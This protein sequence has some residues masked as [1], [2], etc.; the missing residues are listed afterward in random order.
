[1]TSSAGLPVRLTPHILHKGCFVHYPDSSTRLRHVLASTSYGSV[2]TGTWSRTGLGCFRQHDSVDMMF[3][4]TAQTTSRSPGHASSLHPTPRRH[5]ASTRAII[6]K[7]RCPC[8]LRVLARQ[9]KRP[10]VARTC[11]H[12]RIRECPRRQLLDAGLLRFATV[13]NCAGTSVPRRVG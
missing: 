13:S 11:H 10:R 9:S 5:P 1:M 8:S 6:R 12:L 3:S 7:N 4:P 2:E